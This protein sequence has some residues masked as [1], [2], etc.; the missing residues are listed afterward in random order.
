MEE[1][2]IVVT[3]RSYYS[4]WHLYACEHFM[5]YAT[6]VE[7]SMP[8]WQGV[9]INHR[10]YV[11]GAITEAVAFAE[12]VVNEALQ[13]IA[14]GNE[15]Y[16]QTVE[17]LVKERLRGYWV[18][19]HLAGLMT[20]YD[21]ALKLSGLPGLNRGVEPAQSMA[22]LVALRNFLVHFKPA[23]WSHDPTDLPRLSRR[24]EQRFETNRFGAGG[25]PERVLGAPCAQWAYRTVTRFVDEWCAMMQIEPYYKGIVDFSTE[26]RARRAS[27]ARGGED[28][29]QSG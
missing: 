11:M 21:D 27:E 19:G 23:S 20:K 9:V 2:R 8:E 18:A 16:V 5:S 24:L 14:D 7:E 3:S 1:R 26:L 22:D 15:H 25:F 12:A 6:E 28:V 10:A 17:A 13:D 4:Q 29:P